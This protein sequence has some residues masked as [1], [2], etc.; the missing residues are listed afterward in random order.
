M[1]LYSGALG[2]AS[3]VFGMLVVLIYSRRPARDGNPRVF[4]KEAR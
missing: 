2:G 3:R 1:L 4:L